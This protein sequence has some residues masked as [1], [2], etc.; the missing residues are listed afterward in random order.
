M[1]AGVE[2]IG[3]LLAM[4]LV[5]MFI[6]T[7]A[8]AI[9]QFGDKSDFKQYANFSIERNGGITDAALTDI[10]SYSD[11]YF[12]GR[13]KMLTTSDRKSYGEQLNYE[14]EMYITPIFMDFEIITLK[15][16]GSASSKVR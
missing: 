1:Q 6:L 16:T 4:V 2:F 5:T 8:G 11:E 14:F 3:K 12:N 15:D 7:V 10:Q 13:F 9:I